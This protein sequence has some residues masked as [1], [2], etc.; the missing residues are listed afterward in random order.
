[1]PVMQDVIYPNDRVRLSRFRGYFSK[2]KPSFWIIVVIPT[3]IAT[4]YYGL[5][6][7]DVYTSDSYFIVKSSQREK[8]VT[9]FASFFAGQS[10]GG[11]TNE[12]HAVE[13]YLKSRDALRDVNK[14]GLVTNAFTRPSISMFDRF[15][16]LGSDSQEALFKYFSKRVDSTY[17]SGTSV[18][19]LKVQ[20]YT[21]DDAFQI[22][23]RMLDLGEGLVNRLNERSRTDLVRYAQK[24]VDDAR[25]RAGAAAVALSTYRNKRG[26]VDPEKQA[27][28]QIQL[29]TKLQDELIANQTQL[30]QLRQFTPENPQVSVLQERVASIRRQMSTEMQKVAG[31]AQSLAGSVA[32]YER[33]QIDN[34]FAAKQ[35]ASAMASLEDAKNEA[36]R[37]QIYVERIVAPNRPDAALYPKRLKGVVSVLLLGL[38]IYGIVQLLV[39]AIF[40]HRQ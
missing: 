34:E 25:G 23:R 35:L 28:V 14:D 36:R 10:A 30:D 4:I 9:G 40:E 7:S 13:E 17:D 11:S 1:M 3:L 31:G 21:P 24:E 26:V 27:A 38:V 5:L 37:Q 8:S 33:V 15:G 22:N 32:G 19:H 29:V 18:A 39:A 2:L 16:Q 20:A 6:A 12:V